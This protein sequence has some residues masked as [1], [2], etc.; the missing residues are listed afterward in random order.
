MMH[1]CNLLVLLKC[2][3]YVEGLN[4]N[5][6]RPSMDRNIQ[7]VN[8]HQ[9]RARICWVVVQLNSNR[10]SGCK[11]AVSTSLIPSSK[12]LVYLWGLPS[13]CSPQCLHFRFCCCFFFTTC[14]W[15]NDFLQSVRFNDSRGSRELR[16]FG[17]LLYVCTQAVALQPMIGIHS[18]QYIKSFM[19]FVK[20]GLLCA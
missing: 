2:F 17:T 8:Y 3:L 13:L 1:F 19:A 6:V 14:V 4:L 15:H 12:L 7:G 5:C 20:V 10:Q 16:L 18:I 9:Y 11:T